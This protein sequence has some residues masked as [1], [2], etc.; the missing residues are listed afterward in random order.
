MKRGFKRVLS[1]AVVAAMALGGFAFVP[2]KASA[3]TEFPDHYDLRDRDLVTPVK[4]QNPWND[5]WAFSG[6]AAAETSILTL[7][8][9]NK[10]FKE[11][12]GKDFDLSEKHLAWYAEQPIT[13]LTN[14]AQVGEGVHTFGEETNPQ[15]VYDNGGLNVTVSTMFSSGVGPV[16]EEWFPYQGREG[17]T[18]VQ[19]AE[20]YPEDVRPLVIDTAQQS[21]FPGKTYDEAYSELTS[22]KYP[23]DEN[24]PQW[25]RKLNDN[26]YFAGYDNP[27]TMTEEQFYAVCLKLFI[28]AQKTATGN[29]EYSKADDWTIPDVDEMGN[30]NR[31]RYS[32]F[33][34]KDGN[35]LP[36]IVIKGEDKKYA[37]TS[38][39]GINAVKSELMKGHGVSIGFKGDTSKAGE[40]GTGKYINL[41]TWAHYTYEDVQPSHAVCI[42]GW[43]DNYS[44]DNFNQGTDEAGNSKTPPA[45]G[46]FIVKNSWGSETDWYDNGTGTT[47]NKNK[48]GVKN[49]QGQHTGY[50]Y[51][52][53][54]D[55]TIMNPETVVF[56]DD[57]VGVGG[58]FNVFAYD[59]MP[60][61][62][63]AQMDATIHTTDV[64][65]T[66][67][68]FKN[69]YDVPQKLYSVSTKTSAPNSTVKYSVYRLNDKATNPEEGTLLGTATG[70]YEYKG[71]HREELDGSIVINPGESF[72]IVAEE[73]AIVDG[74]KKYGLNV[75]S[76]ADAEISKAL[77]AP[78]YCVAVVNPGE[79]FYYAGGKWGDWSEAIPEVKKS[80]E[81]GD[82]FVIDNFSIKAYVVA[83]SEAMYRLYNPNS[84]E[85][86]Y[87]ANAKEMDTVVEAG[88]SYEG[89]AWNAP[90]KSEAPVYRVYNPNS[91]EHFYTTDISERDGLTS[92]GW[93]DEG[94]GWYSAYEDGEPVYRLYNPNA[95][96]AFE[97]GAHF[98]TM[99]EDERDILDALG[100]N[101]EGIGWYGD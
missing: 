66:A 9:G 84:G 86:F 46:A 67:N 40:V 19:F 7:I 55:K 20:K 12:Y 69:D 57:I 71:F 27:T 78:N 58:N 76:G 29:S 59:Y 93:R 94:I 51:L 18:T 91:G 65:K 97:A 4:F 81:D 5:C 44:K 89:I 30:S 62:V 82:H 73:T 88:W 75:N 101:Y 100:W 77:G 11:T 92:L 80:I 17:L 68:V 50:F 61:L 34:L 99:K 64:I 26:D 63:S 23:F 56:D 35:T 24:T 98:Y 33:T 60:S 45:D 37:S 74:Q 70:T 52:S 39:E 36:E 95:T 90:A 83:T 10:A 85:H 49:E 1:F 32:G 6:T 22:Q 13:A 41:E 16:Y 31:D 28:N 48:W 21:L 43:D 25:I 79:S 14:P 38:Q 15:K 47:I 87:T 72:S 8:G 96:G 42:I 54:Y 53:Y 2:A 3:E